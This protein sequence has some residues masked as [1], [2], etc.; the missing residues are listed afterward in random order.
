MRFMLSKRVARLL[1][2]QAFA[3]A[4]PSMVAPA[5]IAIRKY[6][7]VEA[8]P[9][10]T[11]NFSKLS[12]ET[13]WKQFYKQ[14]RQESPALPHEWL[15]SYEVLKPFV[16]PLMPKTPYRLLDVGCGVSTLSI[17]L[18]MESPVP[19]ESLCIDISN[20]ALLSLQ[21]KLRKVHLQPGSK[22]DFLQ[23]DVLSMPV[24]SGSMDVIIDKGT[25]DSFLKDEDRDRAHTRAIH[26]YKECLRVL[27]PTGVLIQITDEDPALRMGLLNPFPCKDPVFSDLKVN[28]KII[29]GEQTGDHEYFVYTIRKKM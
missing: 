27:K 11:N 23:A 7:S 10:P 29:E 24:Q 28:Y 6:S 4:K 19:S 1:T 8:H 14:Q 18:C 3:G 26:L 16:L 21:E 12:K 9:E 20:D 17:E 22:I 13:Y 15:M 2:Q 5:S 25:I